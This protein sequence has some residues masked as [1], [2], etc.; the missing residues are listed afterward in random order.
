MTLKCWR[1]KCV[2]EQYIRGVSIDFC[3]I[4]DTE[5]IRRIRVDQPLCQKCYLSLREWADPRTI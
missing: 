3:V 5:D 4:E 1:C 2:F